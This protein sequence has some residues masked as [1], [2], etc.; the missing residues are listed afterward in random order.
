MEQ[1]GT[2]LGGAQSR[3]AAKKKGNGKMWDF[4]V[5]QANDE[6]AI[7]V[8]KERNEMMERDNA[9]YNTKFG[10]KIAEV[11]KALPDLRSSNWFQ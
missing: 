6:E 2:D 11:I 5:E 7:N 8:D 1:L 10:D 4:N 3:G 9:E